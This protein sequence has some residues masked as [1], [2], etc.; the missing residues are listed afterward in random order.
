MG[1]FPL[2]PSLR[3]TSP[4]AGLRLEYLTWWQVLAIFGVLAAITLALG[5]RSLASLGPVRRWVALGARLVVL[6]LAVLILAGVRLERTN[7]IVE[8]MVLLDASDSAQQS[9]R[10]SD[11]GLRERQNDWIRQLLSL[12]D[13]EK[14]GDDRLGVIS[15]DGDAYVDQPL[16]DQPQSLFTQTQAVNRR[17]TGTDL[18]SALQLAMASFKS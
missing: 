4:L 2:L 7:E 3:L 15:F 10:P 17:T 14:R 6:L 18:A 11:P 1:L 16:N 12:D 8:V 13:G 9:L 5:V